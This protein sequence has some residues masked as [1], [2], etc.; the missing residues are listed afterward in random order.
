MKQQ[1][2]LVF[3]VNAENNPPSEFSLLLPSDEALFTSTILLLIGKEALMSDIYDSVAYSL[4][5][6]SVDTNMVIETDDTSLFIED[7]ADNQI[8]HWS[9]VAMT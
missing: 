6:Q 7:F 4:H 5:I 2:L 8:Y 9:V 1:V 3:T